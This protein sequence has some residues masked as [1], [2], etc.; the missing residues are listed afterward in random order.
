MAEELTIGSDGKGS[1][2]QATAGKQHNTQAQ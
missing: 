2:R 1:L